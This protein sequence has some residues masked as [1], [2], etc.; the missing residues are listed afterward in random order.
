MRIEQPLGSRGSLKWIQRAVAR[1]PDLIQPPG[2]DPVS[3]LSPLADDNY[4]EYRDAAFLDRLELGRLSAALAEFWP[5]R[6]PQWD[7]LGRAGETVVLVEAKAHA[8]EF[9]TP[10]TRAGGKSLARIQAAFAAVQSDLGLAERRDWTLHFYQ[11]A[12]RLAHLW[13]LRRHGVDARLLFVS[14]LADDDPHINGPRSPETWSTLF[15]A[16]DYVLGLPA[17]HKLAPYVHHLY[18]DTA[19]L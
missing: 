10:R 8:A 4:A 2:L 9:L 12:N 3:W 7:A 1:R 5:A 18:P 6:G 17:R 13:L 19:L 16:A 11:Y 15:A 14:F